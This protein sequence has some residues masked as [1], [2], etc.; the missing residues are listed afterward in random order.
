MGRII[1]ALLHIVCCIFKLLQS[2]PP[3]I[4]PGPFCQVST[5]PSPL[6][7][8]LRD[9]PSYTPPS[10]SSKPP[11]ASNDLL[12]YSEELPSYASVSSPVAP[13]PE[14]SLNTQA[15]EDVLHFLDHE[16]DT[17]AGLSLRYGVPITVLKRVNKI[18]A[19][20]LLLA[21]RT[22]II[23]G[24]FYKAGISLSPR[25]VEGEEEERRKSIV[26]RWM[27]A[28][29]VSEYVTSQNTH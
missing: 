14:K 23:P 28:C 18:S 5:T 22:I 9:P 24:E 8:G 1:I 25:P 27:V 16:Q 20:H 3:L 15:V 4:R 29:K 10:S 13:P 6:P 12:L 19:D 21:R 26:R 17:L 11:Q 2:T 7:Q